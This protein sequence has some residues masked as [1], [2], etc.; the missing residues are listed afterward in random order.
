MSMCS[1]SQY[2]SLSCQAEM[3]ELR[4]SLNEC[5]L[6]LAVSSVNVKVTD[7]YAQKTNMLQPMRD[8]YYQFLLQGNSVSS[9]ATV[10]SYFLILYVAT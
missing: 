2:Q 9:I 6:F 1:H 10:C 7:M 8:G 5:I 3:P 4:T